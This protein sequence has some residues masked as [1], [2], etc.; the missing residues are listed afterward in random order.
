[1]TLATWI[2]R[3][4]YYLIITKYLRHLLGTIFFK[5][6]G[7]CFFLHLVIPSLELLEFQSLPN[8]NVSS[9]QVENVSYVSS[10]GFLRDLFTLKIRPEY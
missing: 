10:L 3:Q 8:R 9:N 6:K 7:T 4:Y 5:R 1:M 2:F